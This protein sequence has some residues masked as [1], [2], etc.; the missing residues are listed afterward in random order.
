MTEYKYKTMQYILQRNK[1]VT[2]SLKGLNEGF[3]KFN[4]KNIIGQF[5]MLQ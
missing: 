5:T 1:N 3:I 2:I 4:V